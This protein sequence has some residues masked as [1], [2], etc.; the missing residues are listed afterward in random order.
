MPITQVAPFHLR[1]KRW[2]NPFEEAFGIVCVTFFGLMEIPERDWRELQGDIARLLVL[3]THGVLAPSLF[4]HRCS[5]SW[6]LASRTLTMRTPPAMVN[7]LRAFHIA[8]TEDAEIVA[9]EPSLLLLQ[10]TIDEDGLQLSFVGYERDV[11]T[12]TNHQGAAFA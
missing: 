8:I 9:L 1:P 7:I 12:I 10:S 3:V 11:H 4:A 6:H 5:L 2:G